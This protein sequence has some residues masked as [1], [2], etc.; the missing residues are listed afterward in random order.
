MDNNMN[1]VK[2]R[3]SMGEWHGRVIA[4]N[5]EWQDWFGLYQR[6]ISAAKGPPPSR[7]VLIDKIR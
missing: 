5:G 6:R 7:C 4:E 3:I 1:N 2:P